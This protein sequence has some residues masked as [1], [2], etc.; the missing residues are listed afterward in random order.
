MLNGQ[1]VFVGASVGIA[2]RLPASRETYEEDLVREADTALYV[3]KNDGRNAVRLHAPGMS[4]RLRARLAM[5]SDLSVAIEQGQF[6][7]D[8]LA[9]FAVEQ[10]LGDGCQVTDDALFRFGI[11]RAQD[12]KGFG[13]LRAQLGQTPPP[14]P[15]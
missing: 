3:A 11:P 2:L 12:G 9:H 1:E 6:E 13:V 7:L 10:G 15:S 5:V 4:D 14:N 8:F